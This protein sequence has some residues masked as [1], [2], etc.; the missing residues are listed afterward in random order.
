MLPGC[1]GGQGLDPLP[2]EL[3]STTVVLGI[4]VVGGT[5]VL[6]EKGR[7][8]RKNSWVNG[9]TAR[10]LTWRSKRLWHAMKDFFEN[11]GKTKIL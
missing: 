7:L 6:M 2:I 5:P 1:L 3:G 10:N 8:Q 11:M 9:D 4:G